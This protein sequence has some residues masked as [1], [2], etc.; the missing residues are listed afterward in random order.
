MFSTVMQ[1]CVTIS[2]NNE[3]WR[4]K[5]QQL[6][7]VIK[8]EIFHSTY[9]FCSFLCEQ[10]KQLRGF[11]LFFVVHKLDGCL[12][13]LIICVIA[14]NDLCL[15]TYTVMDKNLRSS[16]THK[17]TTKPINYYVFFM[18]FFS[19]SLKPSYGMLYNRKWYISDV[20]MRR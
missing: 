8:N 16:H 20:S 5:Q 17:W 3:Q 13:F 9:I 12:S 14:W 19:V 6:K 7:P 11:F 18:F 1:W 2:N 15:L 10:I 4:W